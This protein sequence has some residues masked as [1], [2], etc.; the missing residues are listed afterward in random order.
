MMRL[1]LREWESGRG[2]LIALGFVY[3]RLEKRELSMYVVYVYFAV[4]RFVSVSRGLKLLPKIFSYEW[5]KS[6][7]PITVLFDKAFT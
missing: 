2:L 4:G 3:S 6:L 7:V 1:R 5:G